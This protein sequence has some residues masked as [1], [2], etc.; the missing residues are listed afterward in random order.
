MRVTTKAEHYPAFACCGYRVNLWRLFLWW[1]NLWW[2][3]LR[4]F[5]K[6]WFLLRWV[7]LWRYFFRRIATWRGLWW[8]NFWFWRAACGAY[9]HGMKYHCFYCWLWVGSGKHTKESYIIGAFSSA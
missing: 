9:L 7:F 5:F 6:G 1:V 3:F 2:S 4:R 8:W